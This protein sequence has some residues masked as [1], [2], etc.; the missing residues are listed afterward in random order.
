M[1]TTQTEHLTILGLNSKEPEELDRL[2]PNETDEE[3]WPSEELLLAD[4]RLPNPFFLGIG[5]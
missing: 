1:T 2:T 5:G 4:Y 3:I